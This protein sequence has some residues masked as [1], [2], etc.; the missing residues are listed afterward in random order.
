MSALP[1]FQPILNP[2]YAQFG[3]LFSKTMRS[4]NPSLST[5]SDNEFRVSRLLTVQLAAAGQIEQKQGLRYLAHYVLLTARRALCPL[6][7]KWEQV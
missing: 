5:A 7:N 6:T 1:D 4:S 2:V 3:S